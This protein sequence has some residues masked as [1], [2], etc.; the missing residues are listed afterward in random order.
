MQNLVLNESRHTCKAQYRPH[1]N[2]KKK[3]T[4]H[5]NESKSY[6]SYQVRHVTV[7]VRIFG[8]QS[9]PL[10]LHEHMQLFFGQRFP[11]VLGGG[12]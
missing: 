6:H 10:E 11:P 7:S 1:D 8:G 3:K 4:C 5:S 9:R 2:E 12:K